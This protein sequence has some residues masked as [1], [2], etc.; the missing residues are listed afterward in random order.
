M[1]RRKVQWTGYFTAE[2]DQRLRALTGRTRVPMAT[3]IRDGIDLVLA[4][5]EAKLAA[6]EATRPAN[7]LDRVLSAVAQPKSTRRRRAA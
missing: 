7:Q 2:Q 1:P 3:Y 4:Q 5:E 6:V